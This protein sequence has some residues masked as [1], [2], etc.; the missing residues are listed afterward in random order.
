WRLAVLPTARHGRPG[1]RGAR[2]LPRLRR[3][4]SARVGRAVARPTAGDVPPV[5]SWAAARR[6]FFLVRDALG[7][8]AYALADVRVPI[9]PVVLAWPFRV[10]ARHPQRREL[11]VECARLV[12]E[13]VL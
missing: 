12:H 7:E 1:D 4:A 11:G 8:P 3:R 2:H 10:R 9:L 13:S 6:S 5:S